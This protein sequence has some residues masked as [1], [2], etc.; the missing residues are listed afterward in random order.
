[1]NINNLHENITK[2]KSDTEI[3]KSKMFSYE[4]ISENKEMFKSTTGHAADDFQTV[5]EFLGNGP[6]C[7][8]IK[9]YDGQNNK[10]PKSYPQDVKPG[11]K[12]KLLSFDQFFMYL[13]WLRNC[14]TTRMLSWLF[15]VPK[16]TVSRYLVKKNWKNC[17]LVF[18][19]PSVGCNARNI[20][21]NLPINSMTIDCTEIFCQRPSSLLSQS[22]MYFNYKHHVTSK[23]LLGIAPSGA[24]TF[25]SE[26]YKGSISDKEI[27]KTSGIL[28]KN[29]WDD[30]DSLIF[31]NNCYFVFF[32]NNS[33]SKKR[34]K[35]L[36]VFSISLSQDNLI[37][38]TLK[39]N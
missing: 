35:Y 13:S 22:A 12:T 5:F 39:P 28:N 37:V 27:V 31:V 25:I 14:F 34:S 18:K 4:N 33:R 6:H 19:S 20:Q 21:N 3:T 2:L 30:N 15:D 36:L 29:L 24:I 23:G 9:F 8:N 1:M 26:L 17:N 7:E 11:K 32:V 10:K 16:S 38:K